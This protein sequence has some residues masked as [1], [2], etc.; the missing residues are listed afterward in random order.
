[1]EYLISL[2]EKR[3]EIGKRP[4]YSKGGNY[5]DMVEFNRLGELIIEEVCKLYEKG[6]LSN[7]S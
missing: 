2:I 5:N 3:K 1:M 4:A 7:N 6:A